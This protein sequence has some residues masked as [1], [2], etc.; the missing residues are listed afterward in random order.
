MNFLIQLIIGLVL[1]AASSLLQGTLRQDQKRPAQGVRGDVQVGGDNPLAFII[2]R[3]AT[4]GQLEYA[5]TW[6]DSTKT[7]NA[8]Y[9]E[10]RSVSDLPVRALAGFF[11]NGSRVTL[12][13]TPH[14]T[15]GYPVLQY[16]VSGTDHLWIKFYDG[17]QTT[18]DAYLLN[19]FG[20]DPNRPWLS[21][22]IGRGVAY[23]IVTALVNRELFPQFP[24]YVVEVDGIPL[25]N[26][27]HDNPVAA[28]R[29]LL[30]GI[31]YSG[32]WI[33]GPHG[34]TANHL[35]SFSAQMDKCDVA[36]PLAAG[37]TIA[38]FRCGY[39]VRVDEEPHVVIGELLKACQ[40]RMAE[41]GGRYK[42][43]VAEPDAAVASF[44]DEDIVI[45][46]GQSYE[47][48]PGLEE[49]YN[50]V[51]ATYPE[52]SEA[53]ELK[54]A[55]PRYISTLETADDGRRLPFATSFEAVPYL[56]QV[57]RNMRAILEDVRRF[58]RHSFT[59]PPEWWEY[60]PL[61]SV[62]WTSAWN[63]YSAKSF[64]LTTMDDLPHGNQIVGL[65]EIDP[66][67][68]SWSTTYE[69]SADFAVVEIDR[70]AA[71]P[72]TGWQV[73]PYTF[74]DASGNARR[75]G[76]RVLFAGE[77]DDV[78]AVRVV[79]RLAASDAVVFDGE[80][81]YDTTVTIPSV[82]PTARF[83]PATNYEARGKFL[84]F[85][86]RETDWSSWLAV[87][88]PD[89]RLGASDLATNLQ[90]LVIDA[91]GA[92][93]ESLNEA[94]TLLDQLAAGTALAISTQDHEREVVFS[95]IAGEVA[96]RQAQ[97]AQIVEAYVTAD[98]A[99]ANL[100]AALQ[101]TF[102]EQNALVTDQLVALSNADTAQATAITAVEAQANQISA[103]GLIKFEAIAAPA[104]ATARFSMYLRASEADT[105]KETG[106]FADITGGV[107]RIF[108]KADK[109]AMGDATTGVIPFV[110]SGG[111]IVLSS[112][113][114]VRSVN[115]VVQ[116]DIAGD[117]IL[118]VEP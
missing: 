114:I 35:D 42:I 88:T 82:I 24:E 2:G 108:L 37:G 100:V 34:V 61:D 80:A 52:P 47:P 50:G 85:S 39:E 112:N 65:Q 94:R 117:R 103:S 70:P 43:L 53:W 76:I 63:G 16:R 49:T 118:F 55:P 115:S 78:R 101:V 68:Y 22:M 25:D 32:T 98:Q 8:R 36:V 73:E 10:V 71:Q 86:G 95:A 17:T 89:I 1:S 26:N 75:P 38:R 45:S 72:M 77:L 116:L 79:V 41:I 104:G 27:R 74:I 9:V 97:V 13:G 67:D 44:T 23:V 66:A 28:I 84:P 90:E 93:T 109:I 59:V 96:N 14:A 20:S 99:V 57:Q 29:Q 5:G 102:D 18:A 110:Y 92:L 15:L 12:D 87:T 7:P 58:R 113:V 40:G 111:K 60:E 107:G 56:N 46:E 4:A 105:W 21:D 6:G 69:L 91:G 19:R 106:I 81:P 30:L 11:V 3:Y 51:T 64:L 62:T 54:D 83:L 31:E 48:F 33:Y